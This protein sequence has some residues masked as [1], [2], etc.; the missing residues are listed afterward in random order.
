MAKKYRIPSW[1]PSKFWHYTIF[2]SKEEWRDF[3]KSLFKEPGFYN[4]DQTSEQFNVHARYFNKHKLFCEAPE[5]SKDYQ[6][7]WDS[8][9]EKCRK[10]VI[11]Y[12][13]KGDIWYLPRF[14]YHWLNFLQI[15][16]KSV[17][18]FTF[19][20]I[21]DVQYH[22]GLYEILAELHDVDASTLK[23]R[24][25][26][27]SY[28]HLGKLYNK[29]LFEE[30]YVGK[31]LA[32]NKDFMIQPNGSWKFLDHYHNFTNTHTA[33][34]CTNNPDKPLEWQQKVETKSSDGRKIK[35]GLMSTIVGISLNQSPTAGVGGSCHRGDTKI[36]MSTGKY[37]DIQDIQIEESVLGIDNKPKLVEQL[38]RG[39]ADMY[40]VEQARGYEY[41]TTGNH[42]LYLI[43]RDS[44]VLPKNKVRLT[45]TIDWHKLTNYQKSLYVG[46][47]NIKALEFHNDLPEPTL[48]PY[49]LG[50]WIGDGHR[51]YAGLIVNKTKDIE[52]IEYMQELAIRTNTPISINRKEKYRYNPEMYNVYFPISVDG[53]DTHFTKQFVKYNLYYNKHIPDEFLYGS[54]NT[55]L[56]V[57]AGIIDTDGYYQA[58]QGVYQVCSKSKELIRQYA[59]LCRSLGAIVREDVQASHE[60]FIQ[61]ARIKFTET[62]R[63]YVYFQDTSII[64]TLVY[65]KQGSNTRTRNIHTTPI[66]EVTL[67][68]KEEYYGIQ[69]ADHL[70]YLED[71]TIT[72]NCTEA[73]Y[74][75]GGIAPTADETHIY[76][77]SAMREG[78]IVSGIFSIAGSVGKLT[79]CGPLKNFT[80]NPIGNGFYPVWTNLIDK[81]GKEGW[82]GLFIPEQWG[83]PPYIDQYGNSMIKEALESLDKQD[84]L[85][86]TGMKPELYQIERSQHP[87][88]IEEAFAIRTVSI[89]PAKH[90]VRQVKRIEGG[91]V[92]L[93]YVD[94]ERTETGEIITK[95][96]E[97]E[98]MQYP[99]V[100]TAVDKRGCVVI[101]QHPGK[102][103]EWMTYFW[104]ADPV[105]TGQTFSSESL[106][107]IYIYMNPVEVI[108]IDAEGESKSC[109]E[110][111]KLV[112]EWVGRYDDVNDTNEQM[113]LL[114]EYYNAYGISEKNKPSLNTYMQLKKRMRHLAPSNEMLTDA[115]GNDN[116]GKR[117][118]WHNTTNTWRK[119]L[120]YGVDSLSEELE[121]ASTNEDGKVT[122]ARYGVERI[123]FIWLLKEM[124]VYQA[125]QNADRVIAF[126]A[127]MTFAKLWQAKMDIK[128]RVE[129]V[130]EKTR[131]SHTFTKSS[132][133]KSIGQSSKGATIPR[134][135]TFRSVGKSP[136]KR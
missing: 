130:E 95:K 96:A 58:D 98:P 120:Q 4:F 40:K 100:M 118:G 99:S 113:S 57:L 114:I 85:W 6:I 121:A 88:N 123:P 48:D 102:N 60:H 22:M 101:H 77:K 52:I 18:K 23:S 51:S 32:S 112:A 68:G 45:K 93:K 107:A 17:A 47:K 80:L 65:R 131:N 53:K 122:L 42:L 36:L 28:F 115:E 55:R 84:I 90:T 50:L 46:V 82:S 70:Y 2:N 8:E 59:F 86:K 71:L 135:M 133:L 89:F 79:D 34:A 39:V 66:S 35:I 7:Y 56:K 19:P 110:G 136:V 134:G 27:S 106:A 3:I 104:S 119:I 33:W 111:D 117:F 73:F 69:V 76:M 78:D 127:L 61:D 11:Y 103:P 129:R 75:E 62:N 10:G 26:A 41:Y 108:R 87:R 44:K 74:E 24:Q 49:F 116:T 105:E 125:G 13:D 67:I 20:E 128:K 63:I 126:C 124:Q 43:N 64:P 91:E 1:S 14:Y 83:M 12:N 21:R 97:R 16:N 15:F 9:K 31:V 29:Y 38:F 37:K 94:L 81:N 25:K 109:I 5:G 72:H 54:I 132:F 92:Y 30:G